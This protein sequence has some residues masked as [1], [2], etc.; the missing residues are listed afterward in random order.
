MEGD[1]DDGVLYMD[2]M[3]WL[4]STSDEQQQN[5]EGY[6]KEDTDQEGRMLS[7]LS[8]LVMRLWSLRLPATPV[9][10]QAKHH[11]ETHRNS[12]NNNKN[13][14]PFRTI[15]LK[16]TAA[17]SA[18]LHSQVSVPSPQAST[19][20]PDIQAPLQLRPSAL[21]FIHRWR[22]AVVAGTGDVFP[23]NHAGNVLL[24]IRQLCLM[25]ALLCSI[26][27]FTLPASLQR[28]IELDS[29]QLIN[30]AIP[31][32][33]HSLILLF[34]PETA[35][36][37]L[38]VQSIPSINPI[39]IAKS[40]TNTITT[41]LVKSL[42]RV[43]DE[44]RLFDG[45]STTGDQRDENQPAK[46]R[47]QGDVKMGVEDPMAQKVL[48]LSLSISQMIENTRE[49][50]EVRLFSED[51][52]RLARMT[53]RMQAGW[54]QAGL[55]SSSE[56][57]LRLS[58][59]STGNQ[60]QP[61]EGNR[62]DSW[63]KNAFFS[64]VLIL[65]GLANMLTIRRLATRPIAEALLPDAFQILAHIHFITIRFPPDKLDTHAAVFHTLVCLLKPHQ[66]LAL[67][68]L[69]QSQPSSTACCLEVENK[70]DPVHK[71]EV[72]YYMNLVERLTGAHI[73]KDYLEATVVPIVWRK[74]SQAPASRDA[75]H[76][77]LALSASLPS[78]SAKTVMEL[79]HEYSQILLDDVERD[80]L[81]VLSVEQQKQGWQTLMESV[82]AHS[83][84]KMEEMKGILRGRLEAQWCGGGEEGMEGRTAGREKMYEMLVLTELG[85]LA[86]GG[87]GQ[88]MV[89]ALDTCWSFIRTR[90]DAVHLFEVGI[91][92]L[93]PAVL[94]PQFAPLPVRWWIS[95]TSSIPH[96]APKL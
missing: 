79:A 30:L 68:I 33:Q 46:T 85:V 91:C 66:A 38:A 48:S 53:E 3:S 87:Q 16:L 22:S 39:H 21:K 35:V 1:A 4:L 25:A 18:K 82:R 24:V 26:K 92:R 80:E 88:T 86:V 7:E 71:S 29:L 96:I 28:Q 58:Q 84:E 10:S 12:N 75:V 49:G 9:A 11:A 42:V 90:Q 37:W 64:N 45:L 36:T 15:F 73:P 60:V 93:L 89:Q 31:Q 23:I 69:K 54:R 55:G 13:I 57:E 47:H 56:G 74:L 43:F 70:R 62:V 40:K 94:H 8:G 67:R 17:C 63:L 61:E 14:E 6:R 72:I 32:S 44:G 20:A 2:V 59:D 52:G 83:G 50:T 34:D 95:K 27:P 78:C 76:A 41:H 81:S 5:S 77:H 51:L 65:G 19:A